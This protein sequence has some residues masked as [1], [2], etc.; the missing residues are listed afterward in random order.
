MSQDGHCGSSARRELSDQCLDSQV[1]KKH[2]PN[3]KMIIQQRPN[4]SEDDEEVDQ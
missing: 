4:A 1:R 3:W 2:K